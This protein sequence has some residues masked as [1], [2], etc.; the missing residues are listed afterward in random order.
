[1]SPHNHPVDLDHPESPSEQRQRDNET[2]PRRAWDAPLVGR[3]AE[4]ASLDDALQTSAGGSPAVV[5]IAGEAGIGKSRLAAEAATRALANGWQLLSGGC[6][7]LA[8]GSVPYLPLV[9]A[10]HD[11]PPDAL[12]PLL[13]H[14]VR[15]EAEESPL[16][17]GVA[18]G[19]IYAAYLDV[20]RSASVTSP[21]ALIVEDVHWAD[22]GTRDLLSYLVRA[23]T[24][25]A[26]Q[27][28]VLILLTYRS[29]EFR[30]GSPVRRWLGDLAR[31][32]LVSRVDVT[33]LDRAQVARQLAALGTFDS[34]AAQEIFLRSE[35]N[36]FYVEELATLWA[37][38][39]PAV[40]EIVRDAAEVRLASLPNTDRDVIRMLATLGRPASFDLIHSLTDRSSSE[41]VEMLRRAVDAGLLTVDPQ[42]ALYRFRHALLAE[43][44]AVDFLPGERTAL[45]QA[46]ARSLELDPFLSTGPGELAYHQAWA[47]DSDAALVSYLA[48]ADA[49]ARIYAFG[50]A[51]E[52]LQRA[53]ELWSRVS[54][55][56]QRVGTSRG[57]LLSR[58][59]EFV[60]LVDDF[61]RAT[62][63]AQAAL[64]E[65]DVA[66]HP[67]RRAE[68]WRR[69]AWYRVMASDGPGIFAAFDAAAAAL[70]T[71]VAATGRA[72]LAAEDALVRAFWSRAEARGR[73]DRALALADAEGDLGARGVALNARGCV[74]SAA[75][76][77][78]NAVRDLEQALD[79][80]RS[81]GTDQDICRAILNLA[82]TLVDAA[83]YGEGLALCEAGIDEATSLGLAL[84]YTM[85][86][87]NTAADALFA[88]GRWPEAVSEAEAVLRLTEDGQSARMA[89]D[90][91]AR[92]ATRRGD[93]E[94]AGRL[95]SE[96]P[97]YDRVRD[98]PQLAAPAWLTSAELCSMSELFDDGRAAVAA[99]L[100]LVAGVDVWLTAQLCAVGVRL[101]ADRCISARRRRARSEESAA[102]QR[103]RELVEVADASGPQE[104]SIGAWIAQAHAEFARIGDGETGSQFEAWA[105]VRDRWHVL[106]HRYDEAYA[107]VRLAEAMLMGGSR[108]EAEAEV[109]RS[110]SIANQLGARP[111]AALVADVRLRA[112]LDASPAL[113]KDGLT[114]REREILGWVAQGATNRDIAEALFISPKTVS[115]HVS[116]LLRKFGVSGRGDLHSVA[117]MNVHRE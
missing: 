113:S 29:D 24:T 11:L 50:D 10:L 112:G 20:L 58:S 12:P 110:E 85:L 75:G 48:A 115:V 33:P 47:G 56:D 8:E 25:P 9:D 2:M 6:L 114:R 76:D 80:A 103:G 104:G 68:V 38:G 72:R 95:L 32:P 93:S 31:R 109:R 54:D 105:A 17:E 39:Q 40:P 86:C 44:V 63:L 36:P 55:A 3:T 70:E 45:H 108:R 15:G 97:R 61:D 18:R 88:L 28:R 78:T 66:E 74:R 14:W 96:V 107:G 62:A 7:D 26:T 65:P 16:T 100:E 49:A 83:R 87:R 101:E 84:P 53:L 35:G 79:L 81:H 94:L 67:Q 102:R 13:M 30:R 82:A 23:L 64:T 37:T 98:E 51:A 22:R 21:L 19:R 90:V 57:D 111:L 71:A 99:G 46:I 69:I 106:G 27:A 5:L 1:V 41:L 34:R 4:L 92:T 59:A 77:S 42:T 116:A 91:L 60:A 89:K 73:A 52:C 117:A 43:A